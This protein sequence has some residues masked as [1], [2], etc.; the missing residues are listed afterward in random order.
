MIKRVPRALGRLVY[1]G[2]VTLLKYFKI[3]FTIDEEKCST[4][5]HDETKMHYWACIVLRSDLTRFY[6]FVGDNTLSHTYNVIMLL[7]LLFSLNC[8]LALIALD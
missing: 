3:M 2:K 4:F 1:V 8:Y 6:C 7:K 5:L